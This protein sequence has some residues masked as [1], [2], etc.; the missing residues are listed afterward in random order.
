MQF[1][2]LSKSSFRSLLFTIIWS[3]SL[4]SNNLV[5]Q[6]LSQSYWPLYFNNAGL[7]FINNKAFVSKS[8]IKYYMSLNGGEAL[9]AICNKYTGEI[10]FYST[11]VYAFNREHKVMPNGYDLKGHSSTTQGALIIPYPGDTNRFYL[12]AMNQIADTP[13]LCYSIINMK[14]DNGLGDIEANNK[15]IFL[16]K[17]SLSEKMA[18]ITH[19]NGEDYWLMVHEAFTNCFLAY[20]IGRNGISPPVRSYA[21][22]GYYYGVGAMKFSPDGKMLGTAH[23]D[24][25]I[26]S[27]LFDFDNST[28]IVS[29]PRKVYTGQAYSAEF[30][31]DNSMLYISSCPRQERQPPFLT[32]NKGYV[33]QFEINKI[34]QGK[35]EFYIVDSFDGLNGIGGLQRGLDEMIYIALPR[36][37][38]I[39]KPNESGVACQFNRMDMIPNWSVINDTT[40]AFGGNNL[41]NFITIVK[42]QKNFRPVRDTIICKDSITLQFDTSIDSMTINTIPVIKYSFVIFQPGLY[43]INGYDKSGTPITDT[44]HVVLNCDTLGSGT[45]KIFIP[46]SFSPNEDQI[47]DVFMIYG[48]DI[49]YAHLIIFN[50]W[51]EK[52]WETEQAEIYGW[53]G[54]YKGAYVPEGVYLYIIEVT[55]KDKSQT[56]FKG[57]L[58]VIR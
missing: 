21:G 45:D 38:R 4:F 6:D 3:L 44:F 40:P 47:N 22:A 27:E 52:L 51:G 34:N 30:S 9:T 15:N 26:Y 1:H 57:T 20:K 50:E 8:G 42:D 55:K 36:L 2:L 29:N 41:P 24:T 56:T 54:K 43:I 35:S 46:N 48:S 10:L 28:G 7:Q 39:E 33:L 37:N 17:N 16:H 31:A 53:N 23:Y 49:S 14:L 11:A 19:S 13:S 25:L 32:V 18:G 58:T 12:F 5:S